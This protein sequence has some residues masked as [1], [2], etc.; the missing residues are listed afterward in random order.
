MTVQFAP[1]ATSANHCTRKV[2]RGHRALRHLPKAI[3]AMLMA[4]LLVGALSACKP[5]AQA[6][7][8]PPPPMNVGITGYNFTNEGVQ[9]YYVD[10]SR[11]SNLPAYGGGGSVSCCVSLPDRWTPE[12]KVKVDWITGHW[13]LPIGEI[14]PMDINEAIRCCLARRTISKTVPVE[15]YG[16]KGGGVQVFFLPNDEVQVW[17]SDYGLGHDK[18]PSGMSY[19]RNPNPEK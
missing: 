5:A 8:G 6:P 10:G 17:V 1:A 4:L 3:L 2:H 16:E 19:P 18:H 14:L 15:R 7:P 12:V 9:E 13:T 11:G